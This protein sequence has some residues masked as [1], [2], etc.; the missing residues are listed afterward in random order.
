MGVSAVSIVLILKKESE[1]VNFLLRSVFPSTLAAFRQ[2][3]SLKI[4]E[5]LPPGCAFTLKYRSKISKLT[6]KLCDDEDLQ[7]VLS[8]PS[9]FEI[10][11]FPSKPP[12]NI[13]L[14]NN[15]SLATPVLFD[16]NAQQFHQIEVSYLQEGETFY[17]QVHL[18]PIQICDTSHFIAAIEKFV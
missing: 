16:C 10:L 1:D 2:K 6:F 13:F 12:E 3:V 15:L 14:P 5:D 18:S 4:K 7:R 8:D 17:S 9:S 11:I